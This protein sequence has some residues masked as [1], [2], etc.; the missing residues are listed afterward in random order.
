VKPADPAPKPPR[1]G[2]P[3]GSS[4][5]TEEV[6]Q[7]IVAYTLAG[8]FAQVA[9]QAAG[10]SPRTFRDWMA[11]GEHR[12]RRASDAIYVEF[13]ERI[14]VAQSQARAAAE[15]WMHKE[16]PALWLAHAARTTEDEP[17]WTEPRVVS[18]I[19]EAARERPISQFSDDELIEQM[20]RLIEN[21]TKQGS[22]ILPPCPDPRCSC[23]L[24]ANYYERFPAD[25]HGGAA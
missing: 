8:A 9:A 1:R 25:R 10:I 5:L 14:R 6:T 11:R 12:S 2:R 19:K 24:H 4:L 18:T 21:E 16:R 17:G 15:I 7:T 3:K 23:V 20:C 13:A 22:Y